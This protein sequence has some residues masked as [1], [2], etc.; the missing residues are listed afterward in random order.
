MYL[1]LKRL[2]WQNKLNPFLFY[3]LRMFTACV[4]CL[5]DHINEIKNKQPVGL[6]LKKLFKTLKSPKEE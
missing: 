5:I 2:K 1:S 3:R 6:A 4:A